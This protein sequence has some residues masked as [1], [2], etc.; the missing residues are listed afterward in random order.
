[1]TAIRIDPCQCSPT[2]DAIDAPDGYVLPSLLDG[3]THIQRWHVPHLQRSGIFEV[4]ETGPREFAS[5]NL[6]IYHAASILDGADPFWSIARSVTS[7][8]EAR[9][10]VAE[11]AAGGA[12]FIKTYDG[13]DKALL[14][15]VCTAAHDRGLKVSG[16]VPSGLTWHEAVEAGID[17]IEHLGNVER[18]HLRAPYDRALRHLRDH[19]SSVPPARY[20]ETALGIIAEGLDWGGLRET[21]SELGQRGVALCPTLGIHVAAFAPADALF[22]RAAAF[23]VPDDLLRGWSHEGDGRT[24]ALFLDAWDVAVDAM[25]GFQRVREEIV[26]L[27]HRSG[28]SILAGSDLGNPWVLP[29]E[30]LWDELGHLVL[31]G[32]TPIEALNA[33]T[34]AIR[35]WLDRPCWDG[36]RVLNTARDPRVGLADLRTSVHGHH[37][38]T[39]D[40]GSVTLGQAPVAGPTRGPVLGRRGKGIICT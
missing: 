14:R 13:L 30:S 1:M 40:P 26:L 2:P 20:L 23:G 34:C 21:F 35:G 32:L 25:R 9:L 16:H 37:V 18:G 15:V 4:R 22:D 10:A 24:R 7:P 28:M 31:A 33:G 38:P 11:A 6:A 3:H 39:T 29:G 5:P 19:Q 36:D 12:S 8:N 17:C 27:A